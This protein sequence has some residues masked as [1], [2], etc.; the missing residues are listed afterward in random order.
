MQRNTMLE[1]DKWKE[2]IHRKPLILKGARQTGN[3]VKSEIM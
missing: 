2:D 1:L 3:Y